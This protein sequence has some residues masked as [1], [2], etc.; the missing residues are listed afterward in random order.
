MKRLKKMKIGLKDKHGKEI[1]EGDLYKIYGN[2]H[3]V[4]YEP[5]RAGFVPFAVGDG[6]GCCDSEEVVHDPDDGEV[7]GSIYK[8]PELLEGEE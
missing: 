5:L 1:C 7:I 8:N 3:V 4:R 2:V 6:Y